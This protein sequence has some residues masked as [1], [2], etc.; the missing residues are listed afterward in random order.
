[1]SSDP[2]NSQ[3]LL[4]EFITL[5]SSGD[6]AKEGAL[7]QKLEEIMKQ[8]GMTHAE[9]YKKLQTIQMEQ[10]RKNAAAKQQ[11]PNAPAPPQ[12]TGSHPGFKSSVDESPFLFSASNDASAYPISQSLNTANPGPVPWG[13]ARSSLTGGNATGRISGTPA[14]VARE[15]PLPLSFTPDHR[16]QPRKNAP[17]DLSMRRTIHDLVASVDPNVKIEPEVEDVRACRSTDYPH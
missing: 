12:P 6:K 4:A 5:M 16:T 13:P 2:Q 15:E 17:G 1:M 8:G 11:Q 3:E 7:S 14:Q 10:S 9:M